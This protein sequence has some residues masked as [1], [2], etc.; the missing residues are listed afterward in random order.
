MRRGDDAPVCASA[1]H[2][3]LPDRTGLGPDPVAVTHERPRA[4]SG[5]RARL[6]ERRTGPARVAPAREAGPQLEGVARR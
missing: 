5:W 4:P 1:R 6:A 3:E 2:R